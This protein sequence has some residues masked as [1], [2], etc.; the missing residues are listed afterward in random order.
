MQARCLVHVKRQQSTI[1]GH[2]YGRKIF[3]FISAFPYTMRVMSGNSSEQYM[4]WDPLIRIFHWS[5]VAAFATAWW[6][7]G[8]DLQLHALA[9]TI[10]TGLL[11][12]RLLWGFC[13]ENNARFTSFL[14]TRRQLA[15]HLRGLLR[16]QSQTY[17]GHTPL[18]SLMIY[19]LLTALLVLVVSGMML[20]A[21]QTGVGF[22]ST[23][24]V[25]A[26]F[27]TELLILQI[28]DWYY[29]LLLILVSLHLAGVVVESLIQRSNLV[30]A[31]I[32]GKKTCIPTKRR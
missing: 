6:A 18:G 23:W 7:Q 2:A 32:T 3:R 26:S 17:P 22:F 20:L 28:H 9:G 19:V 4:A 30:R 8:N 16:L 25:H 21:L 31:M 14:P 13:G 15:D 10:L 29:E 27:S 24:A 11:M 1:P 5:M 12:F